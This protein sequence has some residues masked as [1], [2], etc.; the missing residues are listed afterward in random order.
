MY[1]QVYLHKT[2]V[3]AEKMLVKIIQRAREMVGRGEQL[4]SGSASLDFFLS[5]RPQ[6]PAEYLEKFSLLDDYDVMSA[7][8][9][10]MRHRSGIVRTKLP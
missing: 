5:H 1:W 3:S 2:V 6:H 10:W 7:V 4:F 9:N 8:K